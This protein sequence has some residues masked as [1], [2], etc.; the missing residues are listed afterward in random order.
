MITKVVINAEGYLTEVELTIAC[1]DSSMQENINSSRTMASSFEYGA[2]TL[3][4]IDDE[5]QIAK[6]TELTNQ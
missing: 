4:D 5:L 6:D 1:T 3:E 2:L